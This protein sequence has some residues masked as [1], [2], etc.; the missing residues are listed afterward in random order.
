M[1]EIRGLKINFDL[2]DSP[3]L[4]SQVRILIIRNWPPGGAERGGKAVFAG[5]AKK[6]EQVQVHTSCRRISNRPERLVCN[7]RYTCTAANKILLAKP[8][9]VRNERRESGT[10]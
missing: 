6:K 3:Q 9:S 8:P 4:R 1:K 10:G 2:F 7:L 5:H